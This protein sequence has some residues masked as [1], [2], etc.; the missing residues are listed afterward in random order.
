MSVIKD[1]QAER[2]E[3]LELIAYWEGRVNST[4]LTRHF[5]N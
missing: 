2:L 4:L 3:L 1:T 5:I